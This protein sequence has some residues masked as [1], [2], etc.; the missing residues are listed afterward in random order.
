M[1]AWFTAGATEAWVGCA[2]RLIRSGSSGFGFESLLV[3]L[4]GQSLSPRSRR[5][6]C[7]CAGGWLQPEV[8]PDQVSCLVHC[9]P[10]RLTVFVSTE[11]LPHGSVSLHPGWGKQAR[12]AVG[13]GARRL[14][15]RERASGGR[16]RP[17]CHPRACLGPGGHQPALPCRS[18]S[19][20][21]CG[22][23]SSGP[24]S[25]T[26]HMMSLQLSA[27]CSGS[28]W[29]PGHSPLACARG[30]GWSCSTGP[31]CCSESWVVRGHPSVRVSSRPQNE[32]GWP[33]CGSLTK[34]QRDFVWA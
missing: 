6:G 31:W 17:L 1:E 29:D 22:T 7:T 28:C 9:P 21:G 2:P 27:R 11:L 34:P 30:A 24:C 13:A 32:P 19:I 25:T 18:C 10:A 5:C 15:P 14:Q 23:N 4:R 3:Y 20:G 26:S 16:S 12:V 8:I 33:G